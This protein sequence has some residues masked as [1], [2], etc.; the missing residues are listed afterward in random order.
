ML[1]SYKQIEETGVLWSS[2]KPSEK[3]E[4]N[5][6]IINNGKLKENNFSTLSFGIFKFLFR[7]MTLEFSKAL[8]LKLNVCVLINVLNREYLFIMSR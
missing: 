3:H 8:D 7:A 2:L 5:S 4:K 1:S 6:A